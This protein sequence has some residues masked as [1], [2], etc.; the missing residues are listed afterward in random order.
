MREVQEKIWFYE[1]QSYTNFKIFF[2]KIKLR[3]DFRRD[4]CQHET[5]M[6]KFI[7]LPH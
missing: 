5:L 6:L 3:M 2:Q 7:K 1:S 4:P